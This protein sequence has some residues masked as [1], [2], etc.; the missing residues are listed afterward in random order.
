MEGC[1]IANGQ[2]TVLIPIVKGNHHVVIWKVLEYTSGD[3]SV[4]QYFTNSDSTW[5]TSHKQVVPLGHPGMGN[6]RKL[7]YAVGRV[8]TART[9]PYQQNGHYFKGANARVSQL[10]PH[11][12][13][14]AAN[15]NADRLSV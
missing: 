11:N 1:K 12:R 3:Y 10:Q 5:W 13:R 8:V 14:H 2:S 15:R 9:Y 4:N 7:Q 6:G